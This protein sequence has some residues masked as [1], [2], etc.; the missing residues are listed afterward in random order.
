MR[1]SEKP[2]EPGGTPPGAFLFVFICGLNGW[3]RF[4]LFFGDLGY[5][6]GTRQS[7]GEN[8]DRQQTITRLPALLVNDIIDDRVEDHR[9]N[10]D[11][12]QSQTKRKTGVLVK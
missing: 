10:A 5:Q 11:A 3:A 1:Q 4:D 7:N 8:D 9:A 2:P 12:S 6:K